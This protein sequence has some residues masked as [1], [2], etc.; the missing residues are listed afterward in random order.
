M[1]LLVGILLAMLSM[2]LLSSEAERD[3]VDPALKDST[4]E[5][6]RAALY[7][8]SKDNLELL[9]TLKK[10][11]W[12]PR[13]PIGRENLEIWRGKLPLG[14]AAA[15]NARNCVAWLIKDCGLDPSLR[16]CRGDRAIDQAS[17]SP[18][19]IELLKRDAKPDL[20]GALE[21]FAYTVCNKSLSALRVKSVNQKDPG[22]EWLL[23]ADAIREI[24]LKRLR[25]PSFDDDNLHAEE[26]DKIRRE[27]LEK[28]LAVNEE[29]Q[30][31]TIL[32]WKAI[33]ED[34]YLFKFS[35]SSKSLSG[36]GASGALRFKNGY[37]M[38]EVEESWD[39]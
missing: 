38:T 16:D 34:H 21:Q 3:A 24:R 35:T 27:A 39:N 1:N 5:L 8:I 2:N 12:S 33:S 13:V 29:W 11:G 17:D 22:H 9:K 19:I 32:Q 36:G 37:W 25:T 10:A 14:F 26:V 6:S 4:E 30:D 23:F 31:L 18:G 20:A 28:A 7:A 15:Q